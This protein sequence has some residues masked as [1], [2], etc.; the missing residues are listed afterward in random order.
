MTTKIAVNEVFETI[1]G[2]AHYTG[3]PSVFIRLHGCDVG[4]P[5]CDTKYTW[6]LSEGAERPLAEILAKPSG[7]P[8]FAWATA[9]E[10]VDVVGRYRA[11]HVVIT[12]GEPC[13]FDLTELTAALAANGYTVQIETSGTEPVRVHARTWVT[14]SPK[15]DMPG[16][17]VV[18]RDAVLRANELKMPV[19][20][21]ADVDK[22]RSFLAEHQGGPQ[23]VW[24][25]P[26]SR[27][28]KAT[29]LC[30]EA[31]TANGWRVSIQTHELIGIR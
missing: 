24:L 23:L 16:G 9:E 21:P 17:R 11:R 29:A 15:I 19:G 6:R 26:L 14:V 8:T 28:Q 18:R 10:L 27:S 4:C 13:R 30:I 25:Q 7:Q 31:A 20:K 5:W 22:L 12:G 3:T 1:Q 2:E